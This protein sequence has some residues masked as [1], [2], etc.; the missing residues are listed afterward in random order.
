[1]NGEKVT[2]YDDNLVFKITSKLF[3]LRG[4]ILKTITDNKINTTDSP[5]AKFIVGFLGEFHFQ[6]Q[7]RGKSLRE[8]NLI[9]NYVNKRALLA[10]GMRII[11]LSENVNDLCDKKYFIIQQN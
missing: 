4:D 8:T 11:F 2:T 6:T 1:M 9:R 10:S 5:D 3:T 7:A